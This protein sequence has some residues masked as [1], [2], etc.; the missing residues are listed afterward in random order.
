MRATAINQNRILKQIAEKTRHRDARFFGDRPDHKIRGVSYIGVCSHKYSPCRNRLE[1]D[2]LFC[3]E[4]S[5]G[6]SLR[7]TREEVSERRIEK[8]QVCGGIVKETRQYSRH[9]E[10]ITRRL[11]RFYQPGEIAV[12]ARFQYQKSRDYGHEY[13][14][15]QVSHLLDRKPAE[16]IIFAGFSAVLVERLVAD[17]HAVNS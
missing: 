14:G 10:E 8:R 16:L 17:Y 1:I 5:D 6:G 2:F 3:Y 13:T 7:Y 12:R 4:F 11:Y 15:E 9:P